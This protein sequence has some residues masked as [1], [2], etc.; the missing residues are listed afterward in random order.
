MAPGTVWCGISR[1]VSYRASAR[2]PRFP[3]PGN[4]PKKRPI[5]GIVATFVYNPAPYLSGMRTAAGSI[6]RRAGF[7]ACGPRRVSI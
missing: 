6:Y 5:H 3:Q 4:L 2:L 7:P 1:S